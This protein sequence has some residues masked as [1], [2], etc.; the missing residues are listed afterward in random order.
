MC[1]DYSVWTETA[2]DEER[3]CEEQSVTELRV[4]V[5]V[6]LLLLLLLLTC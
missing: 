1:S 6:L 2:K 3:I 5:S 4:C